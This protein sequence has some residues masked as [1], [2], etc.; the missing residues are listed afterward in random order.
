M[1]LPWMPTTSSLPP[2]VTGPPQQPYRTGP[3][4]PPRYTPPVRTSF[5]SSGMSG[6]MTGLNLRR[7]QQQQQQLPQQQFGGMD[8]EN[9]FRDA[10]GRQG[11]DYSNIMSGYQ[12][13]LNRPGL[14]WTDYS[15]ER[16]NYTESPDAASSL[17]ELA[18]LARTG[19]LSEAMQSDLRARGVSPIRAVYGNAQ[20][21]LNRQRS[22][23]GGYAPGM[24]AATSRMARE[25]GEL[26]AQALTNVNADIAGRVQQGR[27]SAA[28]QYEAA[29]ASRTA[30]LNR[31][32]EA[33][34]AARARADEFN[35]T[36]SLQFE[37]ANQQR[38][39]QALEGMRGLYGTTPA[40]SNMFGQQV[41]QSRGQDDQRGQALISAYLRSI[42]R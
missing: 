19:G 41:L 29:T 27:L 12:S 10:T 38:F 18:E 34:A 8:F 31:I 40:L 26:S 9:L 11:R 37:Q 13:V 25:Q 23:G 28:P 6:P 30:M 20:R 7:Q 15:P 2:W 3:N 1:A 36:G 5:S 35:R 4:L 42:R 17:R 32:A 24:A 39:L 16:L 21:N 22:L 14:N 33:N